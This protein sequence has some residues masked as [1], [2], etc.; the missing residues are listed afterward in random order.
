MSKEKPDFVKRS[1][2]SGRSSSATLKASSLRARLLAQ[3]VPPPPLLAPFLPSLY[4]RVLLIIVRQYVQR[5]ETRRDNPKRVQML[6]CMQMPGCCC[7]FF[8]HLDE[9]GTIISPHFRGRTATPEYTALLVPISRDTRKR[10]RESHSGSWSLE[11]YNNRIDY[12]RLLGGKA[13]GF[14]STYIRAHQGPCSAKDAGAN[15]K[16]DGAG[17]KC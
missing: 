12:G 1:P 11:Y 14:S 9:V 4:A 10:K 5:K 8:F 17:E 15:E 3:T 16:A 13:R 6:P 2:L 7:F